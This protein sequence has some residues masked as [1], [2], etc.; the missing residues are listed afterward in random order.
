MSGNVFKDEDGNSLT[1][2][3]SQTDVASTVHWLENLLGMEFP[4]EHWLGSTGKKIDSGDIDLAVDSKQID[5]G[6]F[7]N[8]LSQWIADNGEKPQDWIRSKS[9]VHLRTPIA[10]DPQNGYVQ[11][12][13]IFMPDMNWGS[14]YYNGSEDS[15][16][17][18]FHR[19]VLL[20]SIAKP[21]GLKVGSNGVISRKSNSVISIDPDQAAEWLLGKG[22]THKDLKNVE[23]IYQAL[24]EDNDREEKL[25][26]FREY[27]IKDGLKEPDH[28]QEETETNFLARLRDRIVNQGMVPIMEDEKVEVQGGRAKGIEHLE[29]LIFRRGSTGAKQ[30]IGIIED[31]AKNTADSATVKWDGKPAIVFGRLPDGSFVLTDVAG[32][33]ASGY[34][35]LFTDL[36]RII[37]Q[38]GNRDESARVKGKLANRVEQ[39]EPIYRKLWPML[40][41]S[42]P[43]GFRGFVQGDLLYT[44]EPIEESG[45]LKFAPNTV[46]YRIPASSDLGKNILGSDVGIAM[47]TFYPSLD[48]EKEP[49]KDNI[50]KKVP[51]L[52]LVLP[53]APT[54]NVK[55]NNDQFKH[56]KAIIANKGQD[57]DTLF[58]PGE[59]RSC[60]ITDLPKLCIDYINR[61]VKDESVEG[62][63]P[64][65]MIV[66]FLEWLRDRV[67]PSKYNNI[68]E[69]IQ[70]PRSNVASL[71]SAFIIFGL[72][73]EIKTDL[74]QQLDRQHPGQEG[75]VVSTPKGTT[76]LVN[77]F[78]FTRENAKH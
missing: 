8:D 15:D 31:L 46:Q 63:E 14:F 32:F 75:W 33:T 28:L 35:G 60:K 18:G 16:Y 57:I 76:K 71:S 30:A 56:L 78:G 29:D 20:S 52:N 36:D 72:L 13:F 53:V 40:E 47:H 6:K 59:L 58:N 17:K 41:Q 1:K 7:V 24:S 3:I 4:R 34:D 70:S 37:E 77:R 45:E 64:D 73:H 26:D 10:G 49:L 54:E 43:K 9:G 44:E 51:G 66:D 61:L 67:T 55:P 38:L 22:R 21:H 74:L 5:R 2:R 50:F 23:S 25:K 69:Y 65:T 12:D 27:I 62:F 48:S 68:I 19:N 39:L 11:V 42:L